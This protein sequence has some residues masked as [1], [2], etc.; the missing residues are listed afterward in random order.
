MDIYGLSEQHYGLVFGVNALGI[1]LASQINRMCLRRWAVPK[2]LGARL[3][4]S[5]LAGALVLAA[6]ALAPGFLVPLALPLW[7]YVA[8]VGLIGANSVALAMGASGSRVGSASALIGTLQF[9]CAAIISGLVAATQ[10]GISYPM[11]IGMV[12]AGLAAAALRFG[13]RRTGGSR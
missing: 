10:N 3:I 12:V 6:A 7:F 8:S 11:T 5:L 2:V 13:R 1:M 9:V 4:V